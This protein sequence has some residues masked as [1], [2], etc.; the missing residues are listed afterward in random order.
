MRFV[1]LFVLLLAVFT[2]IA[3]SMNERTN[4]DAD[5]PGASNTGESLRSLKE[6]QKSL[7]N[8]KAEVQKEWEEAFKKAKVLRPLC[9]E[10]FSS[11]YKARME[12]EQSRQQRYEEEIKAL[13]ADLAEIGQALEGSQRKEAKKWITSRMNSIKSICRSRIQPKLVRAVNVRNKIAKSPACLPS[14]ATLSCHF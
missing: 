1:H 8:I 4:K 5:G 3:L 11:R 6:R 14:F 2:T 12:N 9:K 7:F 10:G 13:D